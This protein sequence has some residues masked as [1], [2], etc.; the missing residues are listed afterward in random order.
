MYSQ[1]I[2]PVRSKFSRGEARVTARL[3]YDGT[4]SGTKHGTALFASL[5]IVDRSVIEVEHVTLSSELT[6]ASNPVAD[7]HVKYNII[8]GSICPSNSKLVLLFQNQ[9]HFV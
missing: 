8:K 1:Y 3:K 9:V 5:F 6:L 4:D 2:H 7:V